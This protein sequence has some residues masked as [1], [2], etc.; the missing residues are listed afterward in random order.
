MGHAEEPS[1]VAL[2]QSSKAGNVVA[3]QRSENLPSRFIAG[4]HLA[5]SAFDGL[6]LSSF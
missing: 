1:F 6:E 5:K 3:G 2:S 4:I